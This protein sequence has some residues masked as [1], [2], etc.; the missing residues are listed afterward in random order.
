MRY[1][2]TDNIVGS[3]ING[4]INPVTISTANAANA[5]KKVAD[6]LA[7]SNYRLKIFDGYRPQRGVDH[8]I[9]W[10][11]DYKDTLTKWKFYPNIKKSDLFDL[12]Y[13]AKRSGHSRGSTYDLTIIDTNGTELEMGTTWDYFG[14]ESW[15]T[16]TTVSQLAQDNRN[17]L[18]GLMLKHGFVPYTEEWWYFTLDNEPFPDTYF[19]FLNE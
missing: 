15:P 13:L 4:Y 17:L 18:R 19:D 2:G 1:Y 5:L 14:P 7:Q 3:R 16:D 9:D 8:F 11:Q 10:S 12:N 6:E